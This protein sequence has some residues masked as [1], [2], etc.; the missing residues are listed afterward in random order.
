MMRRTSLVATAAIVLAGVGASALA[1]APASARAPRPTPTIGVGS[2]PIDVAVSEWNGE[3]YVL[4]DGSVSVIDLA[5]HQQVAEVG[6]GES[7]NQDSLALGRRDSRAYI[8][9]PQ[10]P[11]VL[12]WNTKKRRNADQV[13]IGVGGTSVAVGGRGQAQ[14]AYVARLQV[15]KVATFRTHGAARVR[16][17]TVPGN[18]D[19]VAVAP[20]GKVWVADGN[21]S[22]LWVL[23]RAGK[24][25]RQTIRFSQNTG[26]AQAIAF[27]PDGGTVWLFGMG[28]L[29]ALDVDTHRSVAFV[30]SPKLFGKNAAVNPG[31]LAFSPS[32]RSVLALNGTFPDSQP[33]QIA[34]AVAVDTRTLK[35]GKSWT[36]GHQSYAIA[37]DA[38][39][40]TAYAPNYADDTVS[41]FRTPR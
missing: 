33:P 1:A 23:G 41:Y 27:A 15:K 6:T 3:A 20:D 37:V 2:N 25:I 9:N 18:P 32:G 26:P 21:D 39:T 29:R 38:S 35:V 30:K 5:T 34:S 7:Q 13:T 28:G 14:R 19:A 16:Q 31:G 40:R 17:L 10:L 4:N 8:T 11:Y 24:K 12:A 22:V 36:L